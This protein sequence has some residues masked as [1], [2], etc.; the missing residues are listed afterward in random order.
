[1][2]QLDFWLVIAFV[3]VVVG[4]ALFFLFRA[5]NS[6]TGE[7][8]LRQQTQGPFVPIADRYEEPRDGA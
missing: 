6:P 5:L 8:Y 7:R 1:M 4:I 2:W 3:M